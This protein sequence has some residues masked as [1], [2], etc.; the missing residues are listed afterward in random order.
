MGTP[1]PQPRKRQNAPQ[2]KGG[3]PLQVVARG[4][5]RP[6]EFSPE[7]DDQSL[8]KLCA[9]DVASF[10]NLSL[11]DLIGPERGSLDIQ[12]ARKFLAQVMREHGWSLPDKKNPGETRHDIARIAAAIGQDPATVTAQLADMDTW[13]AQDD[14]GVETAVSALAPKIAQKAALEME[15]QGLKS[16]FT[17]TLSEYP[18]PKGRLTWSQ[19][20]LALAMQAMGRAIYT[21]AEQSRKAGAASI[22][23][24]RPALESIQSDLAIRK[25]L[26][27]IIETDTIPED[28][29]AVQYIS[30]YGPGK[31]AIRITAGVPA[32][33]PRDERDLRVREAKERLKEAEGA[34]LSSLRKAGFAAMSWGVL[35]CADKRHHSALFTWRSEVHG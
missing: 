20:P 32:K 33:L 3:D 29:A 25:I 22:R 31:D 30:G 12:F 19:R 26:G 27:A 21:L 4:R 13:I 11:A 17:A 23:L 28:G 16:I 24:L 15:I 7:T 10:F 6:P 18:K 35:M 5:R 1:K 8:F 9:Q 34:I 2:P 14:E